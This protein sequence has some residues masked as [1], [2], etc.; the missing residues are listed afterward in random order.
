MNTLHPRCPILTNVDFCK[1]EKRT[2]H[3]KSIFFQRMDDKGYTAK[4]TSE[5]FFY[6]GLKLANDG[7]VV[8][9]PEDDLMKDCPFL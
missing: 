7:F 2:E 4:R 8:I 3:K 9:D 1:R 5:G 6:M